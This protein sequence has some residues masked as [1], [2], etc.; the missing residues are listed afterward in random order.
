M[1]QLYTLMTKKTTKKANGKSGNGKSGSGKT[2][3]KKADKVSHAGLS[4]REIDVLNG[5][6]K[7]SLYKEIAEEFGISIDTVKK[8]CKNIYRK[9]QA[10]NRTEAIKYS[11]P[12][13]SSKQFFK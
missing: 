10:R 8:H 7:G 5:L 13:I 3:G 6:A 4:R 1:A 11:G 9:L 12:I 2:N